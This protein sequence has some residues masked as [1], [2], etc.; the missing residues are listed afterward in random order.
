MVEYGRL[1]GFGAGRT[2][3]YVAAGRVIAVCPE[4]ADLVLEGSVCTSILAALEPLFTNAKLRPRDEAGEALPFGQILAWGRTRPEREIRSEVHRR[5]EEVRVGAQTVART[6]HLS[7]HGVADL[8]RTQ[9]LLARSKNRVVT[10]S[11]AVEHTLRDFVARTDPLETKPGTRRAPAMPARQDGTRHPRYVPAEVRR[12]LMQAHGDTCAIEGCDHRIWLQNAHKHPHALGG[13]NERPDQVRIC[14]GHHAMWDHG[15]MNW[16][17]DE[18]DPNGGYFRTQ[19]GRILRLRRPVQEPDPPDRVE[20]GG[21]C[22]RLRSTSR[23]A[24][25]TRPG[26]G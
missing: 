17:A 14:D 5:R 18:A 11:E 2:L 16:V 4:A 9:A 7:S 1:H 15:E 6:V 26:F 8:E 25:P 3:E 23:R 19:G 13:G 20:E 21:P 24:G 10:Q 12:A 22:L